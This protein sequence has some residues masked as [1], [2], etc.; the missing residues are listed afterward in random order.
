MRLSRILGT[1][2]W[3]TSWNTSLSHAYNNAF[4]IYFNTFHLSHLFIRTNCPQDTTSI[5]LSINGSQCCWY[6]LL[7]FYNISIWNY[8][9][10]RILNLEGTFKIIYM[11]LDIFFSFRNQTYRILIKVM[12]SILHFCGVSIPSWQ[13]SGIHTESSLFLFLFLFSLFLYHTGKMYA[14]NLKVLHNRWEGMDFQ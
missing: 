8:R 11:S 7:L 14:N 12:L 1:L 5:V 10:I 9:N 2:Q 6:P 4:H 13:T 3:N